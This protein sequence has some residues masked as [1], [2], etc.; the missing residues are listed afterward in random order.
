[1]VCTIWGSRLIASI[2]RV[3]YRP[4]K[5]VELQTTGE[6]WYLRLLCLFMSSHFEDLLLVVCLSSKWCALVLM[7]SVPLL[8]DSNSNAT[9]YISQLVHRRATVCK[10]D[11]LI[12]PITPRNLQGY[13]TSQASLASYPQW[14]GKRVWKMSTSQR[15]VTMLFSQELAAGLASH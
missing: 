6:V 5:G 13:F 1:M 9:E 3:Y 14:D 12:V 10:F 11:M 8:L 7:Y 15:A 2:G 4:Q